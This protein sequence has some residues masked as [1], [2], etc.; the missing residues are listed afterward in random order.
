MY[1]LER[2]GKSELLDR[3][4]N[5]VWLEDDEK[6]SL[7]LGGWDI[8]TIVNKQQRVEPINFIVVHGETLLSVICIALDGSLTY[9]NTKDMQ[10]HT[11][12]YLR[13]LKPKLEAYVELFDITLYVEVAVWYTT[14]IKKLKLLGFKM[15]QDKINRIEYGKS[16]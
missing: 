10:E 4:R 7:E 9:F 15:T 6:E 3:T 16:K 13:F 2:V 11:L 5:L 12:S 14:S 1:K 8:N